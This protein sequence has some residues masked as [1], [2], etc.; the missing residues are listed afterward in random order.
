MKQERKR[1]E[2]RMGLREIPEFSN[3]LLLSVV[4]DP[5]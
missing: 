4:S 3:A 1:E 2:R 5:I